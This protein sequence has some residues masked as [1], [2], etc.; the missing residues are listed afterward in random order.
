MLALPKYKNGSK[1]AEKEYFE[2]CVFYADPAVMAKILGDDAAN[3]I[4]AAGV[5]A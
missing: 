5:S 1:K 2:N 4:G 3:A